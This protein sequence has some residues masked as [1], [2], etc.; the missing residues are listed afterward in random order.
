VVLDEQDRKP[1]PVVADDRLG[2]PFGDEHRVGPDD[3]LSESGETAGNVRIT[4][5][6]DDPP[7]VLDRNHLGDVL[8][9][10]VDR[11]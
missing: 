1:M 5:V 3:D 11:Q 6:T 8:E 9:G 4:V 2:A 7:D 10:R